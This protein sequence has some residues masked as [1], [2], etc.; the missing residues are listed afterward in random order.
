MIHWV[1]LPTTIHNQ[2]KNAPV[3]STFSLANFLSNDMVNASS[4]RVWH[5][6]VYLL[7][8]PRANFRGAVPRSG[9]PLL[10]S[11]SR[12]GGLGSSNWIV[13]V[14]SL[15]N[16]IAFWSR[17]RVSANRSCQFCWSNVSFGLPQ[18][19]TMSLNS[20]ICKFFNVLSRHL[21]KFKQGN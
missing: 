5:L 8:F 6:V 16:Q 17:W 3:C 7:I 21:L 2:G 11:R 13:I 20:A 14:T 19:Q 12:H 15:D 10:L 18:N 1:V 4:N 9:V